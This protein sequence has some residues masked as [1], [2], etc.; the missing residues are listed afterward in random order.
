MSIRQVWLEQGTHK[1]PYTGRCARDDIPAAECR[2]C[3][4]EEVMMF[5]AATLFHLSHPVRA[6]EGRWSVRAPPES[7]YPMIATPKLRLRTFVP[8][9][10]P[11]LV[12]LAGEH[13]IADMTIAVP[14]PNTSEYARRWIESHRLAWEARQSLHW[15]VS[16]LADDRLVG[17]AGLLDIDLEHRQAELSLWIGPRSERIGY[18]AESAQSVLAFAFTG[19]SMNRVYAS[20][21]ARHPRFP[22]ILT[23]IGMRREGLLRQRVRTWEGFEDVLVWAVLKADWIGSL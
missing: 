18:A 19:L 6:A 9:D 20:H 7:T 13:R 5:S 22:R 4:H 12:A 15:A 16:R 14:H 1:N 17:Y 2:A 21:I 11:Q 10:I 8:A 23:G 3:C